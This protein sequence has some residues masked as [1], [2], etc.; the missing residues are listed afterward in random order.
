MALRR[1]IRTR[2]DE[3]LAREL[4]SIGRGIKQ[5]NKRAKADYWTDREI[6][7]TMH[8]LRQT[9]AQIAGRSS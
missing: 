7:E 2:A 8:V 3:Q 4:L 6:Q 9:L 1:R 5:M